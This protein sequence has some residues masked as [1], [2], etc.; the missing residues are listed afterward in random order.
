MLTSYD[1]TDRERASLLVTRPPEHMRVRHIPA[2][3]HGRRAIL[4]IGGFALLVGYSTIFPYVPFVLGALALTAATIWLRRHTAHLAEQ[5]EIEQHWRRNVQRYCALWLG[6]SDRDLDHVFMHPPV[7]DHAGGAEGNYSW[8]HVEQTPDGP[9]SILVL[10][11]AEGGVTVTVKEPFTI[12]APPEFAA[13]EFAPRQPL[14]AAPD[15]SAVITGFRP[16]RGRR[17][18]QQPAAA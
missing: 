10:V 6:T 11:A 18:A 3:T 13:P 1:L 12:A 9:R 15:T 17:A 16:R 14:F 8:R 5:T 7:P 2:R 4:A